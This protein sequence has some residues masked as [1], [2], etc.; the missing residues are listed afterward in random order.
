MKKV[1]LTAMISAVIILL[2]LAAG[3]SKKSDNNPVGPDPN[4]TTAS[5]QLTLN[6]SGY[7]N[8]AAT[9]NNGVCGYSIQDT[10]TAIYFYGAV[11]GDT[12]QLYIIF[13]GTQTGAKP[14]DQ[15]NAVVI[16]SMSSTFI[17]VAQGTTTV[18]KFGAVGEKVEGSLNGKLIEAS[19]QTEL[20]IT[21]TFS[22]VRV[23]DSQ[24]NL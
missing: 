1:K 10:A 6:G 4:P 24:Q 18:S 5:A 15:D 11:D 12:L 3:C 13:K 14:W 22:A 19:T 21:G 9:L 2:V 16:Y 20:N 23:P 8:K 17:G 7:T